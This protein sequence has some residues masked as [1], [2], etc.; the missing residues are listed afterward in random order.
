MAL[1]FLRCNK[2]TRDRT[3]L[4]LAQLEAY[5]TAAHT[6]VRMAALPPLLIA[7]R[8]N[9]GCRIKLHRDHLEKDAIAPCKLH[10]DPNSAK[11][12]LILAPSTDEQKV[13]VQR[14][15]KKIQKCGYKAN[16]NADGAKV[17]PR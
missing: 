7:P 9:G 2:R 16:T 3:M 1:M 14:L 6:D 17:S 4:S 8:P 12:L 5:W 13:W 15:T 10:Y 11:D